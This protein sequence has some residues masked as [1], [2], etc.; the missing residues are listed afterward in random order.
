VQDIYR[1]G[2]PARIWNIAASKLVHIHI[3]DP[4]SC[5]VVIHVVPQPPPID[6]MGYVEANMPFFVVE[7]QPENRVDGG[8]FENVISV[9]SMD[10]EKGVA[11]EPSLDPSK[12]AQCKCGVRLCDC[13]Y[14]FLTLISATCISWADLTW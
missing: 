10:K 3:L 9:S 4:T 5:E 6:A 13:V 1:D 11:T 8:D 7:E 12:P 14:V 2:H